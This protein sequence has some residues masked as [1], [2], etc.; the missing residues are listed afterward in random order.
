MTFP[1]IVVLPTS[2]III[3]NRPSKGGNVCP[4]SEFQNLSFLEL[5]R[6]PCHC[7]DFTIV[8]VL[9]F[10]VAVVVSTHLC[11][12]CLH[13]CCSYV[14]VSRPFSLQC[15]NL[16]K[17]SLKTVVK[18]SVINGEL[19]KGGDIQNTTVCIDLMGLKV[20]KWNKPGGGTPHMKG[21]GILFKIVSTW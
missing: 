4:E 14:A 3:R 17:Q 19:P 7:Q 11:V 2:L 16:A 12:V 13:F 10:S 5:K 6:K 15:R 21:V 8:F 1:Y 18:T 9:L 20:S